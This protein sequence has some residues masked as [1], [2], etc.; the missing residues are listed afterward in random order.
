MLFVEDGP[1]ELPFQEPGQVHIH[2]GILGH[3]FHG[4]QDPGIAAVGDHELHTGELARHFVDGERMG[5]FQ[6][7]VASGSVSRMEHHR[8]LI[9]FRQF[10]QGK[11]PWIIGVHLVVAV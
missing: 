9:G 11:M 3:H 10:I 2:I 6:K 4:V 5:V 7:P 8:H 1:V